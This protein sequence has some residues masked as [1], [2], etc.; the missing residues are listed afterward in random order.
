[1]SE[2]RT[3]ATERFDISFG[4]RLR[5][6][7]Q[8]AGFTQEELAARAGLTPNAISA[9]ERGEHRYPYPATVRALA[10]ALGLSAGEGADLAASVPKRGQRVLAAH[11]RVPALPIARTSLI[12]R[13][14][15]IAEVMALLRRDDVAL[16]T[17]TGPGG[18]GKTRLALQVAT[19]MTSV[20]GDGVVFVPLAPITDA[21]LVIP[22]LARALDVRE[23]DEPLVERL[24]AALRERELLLVVDNL[25]QVLDAV[26]DV[27]TLLT[28]C[29]RLKVLATSREALHLTGEQIY[30]VPPLTLPDS[31]R[32][33]AATALASVAAVR[34]FVDRAQ[35][36]DPAFTLNEA[37]G[38]VVATICRRL[39]GLPL[40]IELAAARIRHLTVTT[41]LTSMNRRLPLLTDGPRDQ[42]ERLRTMRDAIAWSHDLLS[43][44][45]QGVF[46]RL[47][48]FAGGCTLEAAEAVVGAPGA[49]GCD[50]LAGIASLVDKSLLRREQGWNGEARFSMLE[51]EREFAM[52]HL[53]ASGEFH[54]VSERH[55]DYFLNL[56]DRAAHA[57]FYF[58]WAQDARARAEVPDRAAANHLVEQEHDNLRAALDR[59]VENGRAEESLRY[60]T[61]CVAFWHCCGHLQE[62]QTRLNR[63]LAIPGAERTP[64]RAQALQLAG[65]VAIATGDLEIASTLAQEAFALWREL[66]DPRG[67]AAAL[68]TMGTIAENAL[69]WQVAT[70]LLEAALTIWRRLYEVIPAGNTLA[71]LGGIAYAQGQLDRAVALEE[72]AFSLLQSAGDTRL[73]AR[74]VW[75]LGLFAAT[76]GEMRE[77]AQ[78][79]RASLITWAEIDDAEWLFK[80]LVGLAAVAADIGHYESAARLLGAANAMLDRMGGRLFPFDQP[81]HDRATRAARSALGNERFTDV[82]RLGEG[83]ELE[84]VLIEADRVVA[85]VE[86]ARP[87]Q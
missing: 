10:A 72:E 14:H 26:P 67:Q 27:S 18:V 36:A 73:A 66:G 84:G 48:I 56:V 44:E 76:R 87:E 5:H 33:L 38:V 12:G 60:T 23:G 20:F 49:A 7:R 70:E 22:T 16:V 50:V 43:P 53:A 62:A 81:A 79:Y 19:E 28:T 74:T 52:E 1:M 13:E 15:E 55:A 85:A 63:A 46:R 17:L 82:H 31:T 6:F 4:S 35:A 42:P 75:Y 71:L 29:P 21:A 65:S 54:A 32:C 40:A 80:P 25:E 86:E 11:A 3:T 8:A 47:A 69:N 78:H 57:A 41:L 45:E 77:A 61:A 34:L 83:L 51:T 64:A 37:N 59:L 9:L 58:G 2:L 39:D 30:P 68:K 24:Q